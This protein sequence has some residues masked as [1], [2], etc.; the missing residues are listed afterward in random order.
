MA[1]LGSEAGTAAAA[2]PKAQASISRHNFTALFAA[3]RA[4]EHRFDHDRCFGLANTAVCIHT[5]HEA[6]RIRLPECRTCSPLDQPPRC[7][8]LPERYRISQRCAAANHGARRFDVSASIEKSIQHRNVIA[9][10]GPMERR[11][12]MRT[13][14]P[15]VDFRASRDQRDHG[16]CA[17]WKMS[18]PVSCHMQQRSRYPLAVIRVGILLLLVARPVTVCASDV[19]AKVI[20]RLGRP[21]ANAVIDIHWLKSVS[22][23]DVRK[24][25]LVKLVSDRDGIVKGTYDE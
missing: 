13:G 15:R 2:V 5:I 4:S 10:C 20:D 6:Q 24:I 3:M 21:V 14:E 12:R 17:V 11:L 23:D 9:A 22:K 1:R 16:S 19:T 7:F 8:P 18:G 25:D